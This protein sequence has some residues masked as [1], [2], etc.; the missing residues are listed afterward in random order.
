MTPITGGGGLRKRWTWE[1]FILEWDSQHGTVEKYNKRG[2]H[3]CEFDP[4]TGEETK[5]AVP[6]RTCKI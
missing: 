4:L 6:G 3:M 1:K 5:P 2:H